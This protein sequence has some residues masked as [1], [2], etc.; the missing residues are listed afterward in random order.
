[1]TL[2]GRTAVVTGG[3]SGIGRGIAD[4]LAAAGANVAVADVR[5]DPK[6]GTH[7]QTDATVPTDEMVAAEHGVESTYVQTDVSREDD[8]AEL[9]AATMDRFGRLDILVNNAG[10]LIPGDSQEISV[11]DWRAVVDVNLTGAFMTAKYALPYLHESPQGRIVNVSSVNAYFGGAG[12]PYAATKA[13][14]PNLARDLAVEAAASDTT[15]NT[16]LPGVIGT[17]MQDLNDEET[18]ERQAESTLLS[19]V[20]TPAD[21]AGAVRFLCSDEAE[22]ITGAELVVDGGYL[23]AGY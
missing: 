5:R 10:I 21:V 2:E 18:L 9:V 6:Q 13:A 16:V 19:R 8:V 14:L 15:V 12:P 23:A 11:E 4:R 7:Y 17:P 1:M 20:G 3:A 22:W